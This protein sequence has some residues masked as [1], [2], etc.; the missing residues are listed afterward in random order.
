MP[1][2][3]EKANIIHLDTIEKAAMVEASCPGAAYIAA[4]WLRQI[5]EVQ[6][7]T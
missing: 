5:V 7:N 3:M 1:S 6:A 2:T 4:A